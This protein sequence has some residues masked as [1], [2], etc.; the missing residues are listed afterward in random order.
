MFTDGQHYS[1]SITEQDRQCTYN[2]TRRRFHE[3]TFALDSNK[4]V[5][6]LYICVCVCVRMRVGKGMRMSGCVRVR[7]CVCVCGW[8]G[9]CGCT[10]AAVC[11]AACRLAYPVCHA[12][13]LYF[14]RLFCLHHI[15]GHYPLNGAIF[16]KK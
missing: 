12:Q 5:I 1:L 4:Y 2:V 14:L 9:L 10:S 6:F 3:T 8:E 7:V 11:L 13:S 16:G 15:F